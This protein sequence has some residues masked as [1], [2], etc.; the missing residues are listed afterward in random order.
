M[1]A[2][3]Q[4]RECDL[5]KLCRQLGARAENAPCLVTTEGIS[6]LKQL[7]QLDFKKRITASDALKHP[8]VSD[9][10]PANISS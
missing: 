6:L 3:M 4:K 10:D 1:S 5:E 9:F 2:S 8:F 7:L